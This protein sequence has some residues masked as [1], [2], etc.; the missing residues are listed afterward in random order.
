M[1]RKVVLPAPLGPSRATNSPLL[2]VEVHAAQDGLQA[3][4]FDEFFDFDHVREIVAGCTAISAAL[5]TPRGGLIGFIGDLAGAVQ[6]VEGDDGIQDFLFAVEL[7]FLL[8]LLLQFLIGTVA[9]AQVHPHA[10]Q[11]QHQSERA[12]ANQQVLVGIGLG[13]RGGF[14]RAAQVDGQRITAFE[15]ATAELAVVRPLEVLQIRL[16]ST[17][18]F[19][20]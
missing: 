7:I 17:G 1:R 8:I 11:D 20:L 19:S 5:S 10:R 4:S 12:D 6:V 15:R 3:K 18:R 9:V 14:G 2:H 13:G 16:P